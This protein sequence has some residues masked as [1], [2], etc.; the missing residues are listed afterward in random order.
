MEEKE[1]Q[2]EPPAN[3]K[4]VQRRMST[5]AHSFVTIPLETQ[6]EP[7]VSS[8]Q[9]HEEPS[10]VETSKDSRT[11]DHKSSGCVPKRI[12]R[13][14]L[15]GYIRWQNILPEGYPILMKKG[16]KGLVG[17]PYER[18]RCSIFFLFYFL[19]FTFESFSFCLFISFI[20]FCF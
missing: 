14:K 8:F 11:Q 7:Q 15:L 20:L 19:H 13:S 1:K 9:C 3:S 12:F 2:I 17:H 18:R 16:W 4:F 6:L 5:G 10:Y